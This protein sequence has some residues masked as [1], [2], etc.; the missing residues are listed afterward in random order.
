LD[1][2]AWQE[3]TRYIIIINSLIKPYYNT[4][5]SPNISMN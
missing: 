2:P 3:N 5:V 4:V 1:F